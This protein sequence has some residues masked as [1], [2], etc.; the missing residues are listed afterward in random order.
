MRYYLWSLILLPLIILAIF[1]GIDRKEGLD[2]LNS[3]QLAI[4]EF[5]DTVKG[6]NSIS[7]IFRANETLHARCELKKGYG[8]PY[9]GIQ[10]V[11]KDG[12]F[13][14]LSRYEISL[15]LKVNYD[16]R[17]S[18][19]CTQY[20]DNY[21]DTSA[22]M[23]YLLRIK[24]FGL[25]EGVNEINLK[26]EDINEIP[27]WWFIDNLK[28]INKL[29]RIAYDKSRHI[30]LYIESSTPLNKPLDLEV[31][32]FSFTY[33]FMPVLY[34]F[35]VFAFIYYLILLLVIWKV[36]KVKHILL[37]I[38]SSNIGNKIPEMQAKVLTYI[39]NNYKNADL[40]LYDISS[41]VGISQDNVS[42]LIRKHCD[43]TVR[44]YLNKVRLE[45]AKR[46]IRAT[47][48][49]IAEIA[50]EVGYNNVQHFNRV[51]KEYTSFTPK[52]FRELK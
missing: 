41:D 14:D 9:S 3:D 18:L 24:S 28:M 5:S 16:V 38:E 13:I 19:R 47:D 33:S 2:V 46:L 44:Q 20:L 50:Y 51:F 37:P 42:E 39:A 35:S 52:E 23:S 7:K 26:I 10:F 29:G 6:G 12:A 21:T 49:Q 43:L 25:T 22:F 40:K 36:K 45:E 27:D 11:R 32:E 4:L 15:K 48:L 30:W 8:F 31:I 17:I 1:Y 34:R